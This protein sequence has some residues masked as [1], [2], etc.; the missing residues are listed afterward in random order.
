[1]RIYSIIA[2]AALIVAIITTFF[3]IKGK[4]QLYWLSALGIYLFSFMSGLSIGIITV[5]LTFISLTLATGYTLNLIKSKEHQL[6]FL[7]LGILIGVLMVI[8]VGPWLF[9]P[10]MPLFN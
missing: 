2:Y 10:L 5:G 1:M 8:Y 4:H 9:F 6:I 3:A 7:G